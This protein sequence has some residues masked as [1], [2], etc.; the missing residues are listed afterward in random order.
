MF[1]KFGLILVAGAMLAGCNTT[2]PGSRAL[3]GAAVGG[4]AGA[5]IGAIAG[6]GKR[7]SVL[8]GAGVGAGV[9]A[10][11]GVATSSS[12]S[13]RPAVIQGYSESDP[14]A[15]YYHRHGAAYSDVYARDPYADPNAPTCY[16]LAIDAYGQQYCARYGR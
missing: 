4:L 16:E 2:D 1:R 7:A 12:A 10:L 9:G 13:G 11:A 5:G 6:H 14:S 8:T 3:G 15:G